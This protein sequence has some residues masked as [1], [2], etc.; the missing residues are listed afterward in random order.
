MT[1][2]GFKTC[3][4]DGLAGARFTASVP[5]IVV[6][7]NIVSEVAAC[8]RS[9]RTWA[10]RAAFCAACS[11]SGSPSQGSG[12]TSGSD[13]IKP[14]SNGALLTAGGGGSCTSRSVI[15]SAVA[16]GSVC[17]VFGAAGSDNLPGRVR[18]SRG[19]VTVLQAGFR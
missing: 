18:R 16:S 7:S 6:G 3:T 11:A 13:T 2:T 17:A 8:N 15:D 5:A 12:R 10:R 19:R 14:S 1:T 9:L 4:G